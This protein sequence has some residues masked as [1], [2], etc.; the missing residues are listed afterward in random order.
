MKTSIATLSLVLLYALCACN[1][2][3][4]HLP[5][6]SA[7]SSSEP[8]ISTPIGFVVDPKETDSVAV[9][10]RALAIANSTLVAIHLDDCVPWAELISGQ[11]LPGW[12]IEGIKALR[13]AIPDAHD[14]SL[15]ITP[16][17]MD[18]VSLAPSCGSQNHMQEVEHP[19]E[20][21]DTGLDDPVIR[22]AFTEYASTLIE[23]LDPKYLNIG[24]EISELAVH[25][26][27]R[28]HEYDAFF[29]SVYPELKSR[30]ESLLVGMEMVLQSL[31]D[32]TA[33]TMLMPTFVKGDFLCFSFYPYGSPLAE[34]FLDQ[35]PLPPTPDQWRAG[36]QLMAEVSQSAGKPLAFCETGYLSESVS[37]F[38][39]RLTGDASVQAM[40]TRELI[41]FSRQAEA[42]FV[43][44][45]VPVDFHQALLSLPTEYLELIEVGKIWSHTGL[46]NE[47]RSSKP[48][49]EEWQA[50]LPLR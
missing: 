44:W 48:A 16:T 43:I 2:E 26:P 11:P 22:S 28:W 27:A 17:A 50:G 21:G 3:A 19:T 8:L 45:Y 6:N 13:A 41:A 32:G 7:S 42:A 24:I 35:D 14:V 39:E 25:D 20:I 23:I 12:K 31:M 47:D 10:N 30:H 33:R 1:G 34:A 49:L 38:G 15:A 46:W 18:R 40:Y 29:S 5:I 37:V 36:F 9:K 4:D